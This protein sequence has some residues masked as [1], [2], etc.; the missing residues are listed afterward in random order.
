MATD[1]Q[2]DAKAH[3]FE[4]RYKVPPTA[5]AGRHSPFVC[6]RCT[7]TPNGRGESAPSGKHQATTRIIHWECSCLPSCV[8]KPLAVAERLA[9][10]RAAVQQLLYCGWRWHLRDSRFK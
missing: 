4:R 9:L 2:V 3:C 6:T 5:Y 10:L 1:K 7:W 8:K